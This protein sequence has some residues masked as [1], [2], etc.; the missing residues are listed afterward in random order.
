MI[1]LGFD[2]GMKKIGV[3]SG[4][5]I[6]R[7]ATPLG[8][9]KAHQGEPQWESLDPFFKEWE[10][11]LCIIGLALHA[12]GSESELALKARAFAAQ[13]EARYQRYAI[14]CQFI[15]E[16]L[17]SFSAR[18]IAKNKTQKL[19]NKHTV[20]AMAAMLILESWLENQN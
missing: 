11:K 18:Q 8:L 14:R 19:K 17:T 2:F 1:V 9:I 4:Q 3:A 6:T 12:D 16:H 20:D 10:P 7:T 15:D 5:T 13:L